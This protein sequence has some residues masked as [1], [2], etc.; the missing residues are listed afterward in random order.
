[1]KQQLKYMAHFEPPPPPPLLE[2]RG[3]GIPRNLAATTAHYPHL[4]I[5]IINDS[6][7]LIIY[8]SE[9]EAAAPAFVRLEGEGVYIG[10]C[11]HIYLGFDL[12]CCLVHRVHTER[13]L[14]IS[15]VHSIMME[16][17]ALVGKSGGCRNIYL[18]PSPLPS[19]FL[20][21]LY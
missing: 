17:S 7:R 11:V 3:P 20:S 15:G 18:S 1:M 12:Y 21:Y 2:I 8:S 9:C 14:P 19:L 16:K 13:Q 4:I 6:V 5:I 10:A